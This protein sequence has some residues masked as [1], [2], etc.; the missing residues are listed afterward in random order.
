MCEHCNYS[1]EP[2]GGTRE[3]TTEKELIFPESAHR[4]QFLIDTWVL[5]S[6]SLASLCY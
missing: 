5:L 2:G 1:L 6:L 4:K 3:H